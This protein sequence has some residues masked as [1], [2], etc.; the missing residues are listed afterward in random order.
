M[1]K[2]IL[3]INCKDRNDDIWLFINSLYCLEDGELVIRQLKNRFKYI[4]G[5]FPY[6][7]HNNY[8]AFIEKN[9]GFKIPLE[10]DKNDTIELFEELGYELLFKKDITHIPFHI[11]NYEIIKKSFIILDKY[12]KRSAGAYWI[13]LFKRN[14]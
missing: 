13:S 3:E 11:Y 9:P 14:R 5:I 2:D 10:L 1:R 8:N 4:I 7:N 12:F 6:I